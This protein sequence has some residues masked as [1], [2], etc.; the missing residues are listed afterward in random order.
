MIGII[1]LLGF[2]QILGLI[3]AGVGAIISGASAVHQVNATIKAEEEN[4]NLQT[5]QD[6]LRLRTNAVHQKNR[7]HQEIVTKMNTGTEGMLAKIETQQVATKE[8]ALRV[9]R[10][11]RGGPD[12]RQDYYYGV[13][14]PS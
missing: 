11:S 12:L 4:K 5:K 7:E 3:I 10:V 8:K 2:V 14:V 13:K 6:N 9:E 1:G